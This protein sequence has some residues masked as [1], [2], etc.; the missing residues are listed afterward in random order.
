MYNYI[1]KKCQ[2]WY[3][4]LNKINIFLE[5]KMERIQKRIAESGIASRR[6][7]EELILEGRVKVNGVVVDS[8]GVKV[9]PR[10]EITLDDILLVRVQKLYLA[11][12]KPRGIISTCNDE[13]N[14]TTVIDI[15]PAELKDTRL[16]P[17]GR[18]DYD[19]KGVLLLTNDGDFMNQMVGPSSG[20][21]KEYL[22][23]IKGV[24]TNE[25]LTKLE[26]GVKINGRMTLPSIVEIESIDRKNNSSLVR[27]TIT[28][29]MYHQVKEMFASIGHEVKKLTRVRF[30]N[31]NINDLQEGEV[32]SLTVHEVKQLYDL[33]KRSKILK[34]ERIGNVRVY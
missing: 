19:T 9:S 4:I 3:N 17:V 25:E 33:A 34:K 31:I 24:I 14:R 6:K 2:I 10:D 23:R 18:L 11:M 21:Q 5:E 8:L 26:K 30:G 15:L 20:I 13:H 22:A 29:G 32:R 1:A 7:A 27:I 12:N 28:E 16:F